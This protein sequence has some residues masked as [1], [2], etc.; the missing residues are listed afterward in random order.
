VTNGPVRVKV[1][2]NGGPPQEL[3]EAVTSCLGLDVA[4]E[5]SGRIRDLGATAR[6]HLW[7]SLREGSF[8]WRVG[9]L[10]FA[11][12][13]LL[14]DVPPRP[15]PWDAV[16]FLVLVIIVSIEAAV[17]IERNVE[18]RRAGAQHLAALPPPGTRVEVTD[19]GG[20]TIGPT[21]TP[22]QSLRLEDAALRRFEVATYY[23]RKRCRVDRLKLA[24]LD[25][26]VVLDPI[27]IESGQTIV[28]TIWRRLGTPD[29]DV[30]GRPAPPG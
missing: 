9:V 17:R 26:S 3:D 2:I 1:S 23:A 13:I 28:D 10:A 21:Q 25:G 27:A 30:A 16:L 19:T 15:K 12:I 20:L 14:A 4:A 11:V 8:L 18:W 22:W 6:A 29:E 5:A 7:R 24:T